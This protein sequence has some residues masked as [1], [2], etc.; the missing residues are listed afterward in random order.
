MSGT[1]NIAKGVANTSIGQAKQVTGWLIGSNR[2]YSAGKA[3]EIQGLA[4]KS[5][6]HATRAV[7]AIMRRKPA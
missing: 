4:Q 3:Q 5:I 7:S 6:G 2:L 1:L